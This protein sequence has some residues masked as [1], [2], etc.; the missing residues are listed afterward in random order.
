MQKNKY[1]IYIE[2]LQ[3]FELSLA[4][5][6]SYFNSDFKEHTAWFP[7]VCLSKWK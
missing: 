5:L 6:I 2:Y 4:V 7:W 1:S 3:I